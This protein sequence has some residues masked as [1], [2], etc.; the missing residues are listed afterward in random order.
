VSSSQDPIFFRPT[1]PRTKQETKKLSFLLYEAFYGPLAL[2][3]A[4][5]RQIIVLVGMFVWGTLIFEYYEHLPVLSAFLASVSTI[6][7]IGLYVPNGGNFLSINR[8]EAAL[9]VVMIVLS[10]GAGASVLQSAVNTAVNTSL[11]LGETEKRLVGR[12]KS[13]VI[14][15][16]Y[17]H[18]GRYVAEKLDEMGID[19]VV[20]TKDPNLFQELLKQK[21][22]VVFEAENR[23]ISTLKDAGIDRASMVVI[24][25]SN[26]PDNMLYI[27]SARKLRPDIRIVT[28]V[29][30]E[31]LIETAKAAG[32]DVVIPS[33]VTVGHLLALSAV[34]KD[35]VG[36]VFS[37]KVGTKEIAE[38]SIFKGSVL[39]GKGLQEVADLATI[40]GVVRKEEV[41]RSV[42]DPE[43]KL[44]EGD[45]LLVLGDPSKLQILENQAGAD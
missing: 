2:L 1:H 43:F 40:I 23:P 24:A 25:H 30:D 45:T 3:K 27:L 32:A 7:T 35:L 14:I 38:F 17:T 6:T 26:D 8:T 31:A 13:H 33:S 42:F 37:E 9:L 29:H 21:L 39:V 11:G 34:T 5:Y 19:Y 12:L 15:F 20:T 28:V 22:L 41:I 16:G 10:V 44:Q 18:M 4:V 36:V